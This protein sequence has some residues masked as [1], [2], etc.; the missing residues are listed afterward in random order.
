MLE[1]HLLLGDISCQTKEYYIFAAM[2]VGVSAW[3]LKAE[4]A[5]SGAAGDVEAAGCRKEAAGNAFQGKV[6]S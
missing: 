5:G 1:G 3:C 2:E 6:Q 4:A